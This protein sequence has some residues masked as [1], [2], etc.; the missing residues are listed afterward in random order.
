[1]I[2]LSTELAAD[3]VDVAIATTLEQRPEQD[4]GAW[5]RR[6][7]NGLP[8][9]AISAGP[10]DAFGS[11]DEER[12][13]RAMDSVLEA[14]QPDVVHITL[15]H[16]LHPSVV[17]HVK[18]WGAAVLLDCHS[19]ELG[20][21]RLLLRRTDG[22]PCSGPEGGRA[23]ASA[24]FADQPDAL[25]S[26]QRW[27][28]ATKAAARVAD[29]VVAC[30]SFVAE[31]LQHNCD[32]DVSQVISPPIAP[33]SSMP[34]AL[35]GSPSSRGQLNLA[36]IGGVTHSKAPDTTIDAIARA[37]LGPTELL[38]LG[39]VVDDD[40]KAKIVIRR[41]RD[42][43]LPPALRRCLRAVAALRH[44]VRGRCARRRVADSRDLLARRP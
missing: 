38:L 32:V 33:P 7:V 40:Y 28:G 24:C 18:R 23:C 9:F 8:V 29:R 30:S 31:W 5:P 21:P 14:W 35:R 36:M 25:A 41:R 15:L 10:V 44:V 39:P 4:L 20:C 26:V 22:T 42:C 19:Y 6:A 3:G 27:L 12:S 1:M 34:V 16:G 17:A 13:V 2:A 37:E 11:A 43:R